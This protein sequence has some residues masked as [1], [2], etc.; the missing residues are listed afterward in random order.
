VGELR[1]ERQYRGDE[2]WLSERAGDPGCVAIALE[3]PRGAVV[4]TLVERGV[5]VYAINP[6]QLDRF[7]DRHSVSGAKDARRDAFV[8]A[9]SVRTDRPCFRRVRLEDPLVIQLRELS[10]IDEDLRREANQLTNRLREQLQRFYA[11]MLKLCPAAD[12]P[13]LWALLELA[14]SPG[15]A[16]R[17]RPK[18]LEKLLKEHRIRRLRAEEVGAVLQTPALHVAPGVVEAATEHIALLLPRLRL[19]HAQR[20]RCGARIEA[21]LEELQGA[22]DGDEEPPRHS[23]VEILRSLPGVG[24]IVAA[25]L[26][27]EAS[28]A[29]SERDYYA[30]RAHAGIAPITKQSGKHKMV[31]M[32]Y[33][34]NGRLRNALYHWARVAVM[35]DPPSK[36]YYAALRQRGRTHGRTLR[37]VADR[38]LR[39]L[40]TMLKTGTLFDPS[41]AP[42]LPVN[43]PSR[44]AAEK[45]A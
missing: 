21:L 7:R 4:E 23:D 16:R 43:L 5:H 8:L 6:K 33:A 28:G 31:L 44:K 20:Q 25:T 39:I 29:L 26:I 11:Q 42:S 12:E 41:K 13:W 1:R 36:N 18:R 2:A 15:A 10:R 24:K 38:L 40:I 37:A 30:L 3:I 45:A 35:C 22:D 27:A 14:P 9:D 34:C 32:R 17:L 19:V